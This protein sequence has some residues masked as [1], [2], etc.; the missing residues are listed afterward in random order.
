[1]NRLPIHQFSKSALLTIT[2]LVALLLASAPT[3]HAQNAVDIRASR[4]YWMGMYLGTDK[5]GHTQVILRPATYKNQPVLEMRSVGKMALKMLGSVTEQNSL[6][7][8]LVDRQGRPLFA[9]YDITSK[10]SSLH[11]ET[12]YNYKTSKVECR[13]GKGDEVTKKVLTIPSGATILADTTLSNLSKKI[14][15]GTKLTQYTIDPISI[16]FQK[17]ETLYVGRQRIKDPIS[18]KM[19]QALYS[20]TK[21]PQVEMHYWEAEDGDFLRG[22]MSLGFLKIVMQKET[23]QVALSSNSTLAPE[24]GYVPPKD[25]AVA[26]AI[27]ADKPITEPRKIQSLDLHIVGIPSKELILS[28]TGQTVQDITQTGDT[29][30]ADYKIRTTLFD[31]QNSLQYPVKK[32]SLQPYLAKAPYLDTENPSIVQTAKKIRGKEMNLY[33]IAVAIRDWVSKNMTPDPSIGVPRTAT[34]IFNNRRGVCRDYSTLYTAIARA[35]GVPTRLCGGIVYA[36]GRFFY[37]AWVECYVGEWVVF[38]PTLHN[39]RNPVDYV[40][41]THVKFAQGDVMQMFKVVAIVGKLQIK[42]QQEGQ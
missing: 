22:E 29:Y 37:H 32:T 39:L 13:L 24:E 36:E 4:E 41:A 23:K 33:K 38:D 8:T 25:F 9:V 17:V 6:Q 15:P 40:D 7:R 14:K 26:T 31:A 18:G 2:S 30:K 10:T 12:L 1:M 21:L 27:V 34:D 3:L 20:K 16:E 35:A 42:V 11:L 5:V 28:D 19:V